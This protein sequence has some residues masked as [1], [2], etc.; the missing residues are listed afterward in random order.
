[1]LAP[2]IEVWCPD[3]VGITDVLCV[4]RCVVCPLPRDKLIVGSYAAVSYASC[5]LIWACYCSRS[6]LTAQNRC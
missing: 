4:A 5:A 6:R 2:H 1:M 3:A